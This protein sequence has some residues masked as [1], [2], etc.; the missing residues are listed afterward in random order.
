MSDL[1]STHDR[2]DIESSKCKGEVL[3]ITRSDLPLYCPPK[4]APTWSLHPRVFLNFDGKQA[5]CPY[6]GAHY[7]LS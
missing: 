3:K 6:C 1:D 5:K 7:E 4:S 2:T